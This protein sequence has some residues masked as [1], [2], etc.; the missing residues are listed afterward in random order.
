MYVLTET[1]NCI[2]RAV[3]ECPCSKQGDCRGWSKEGWGTRSV[4]ERLKPVHF[5]K[6][7]L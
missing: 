5:P 1:T 6:Y 7:I 3:L 4:G 2:T